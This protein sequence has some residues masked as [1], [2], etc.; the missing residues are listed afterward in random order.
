MNGS[1]R[2]LPTLEIP[3]SELRISFARSGGKG[4]QNVNKVE[5]KVELAFD[6]LNSPSLTP[7]QR[8]TILSKL[9]ARIDSRGVLSVTSQKYRSQIQNRN[10]AIEK[11]SALLAHALTPKKKR[12]KTTPTKSSKEKRLTAKK[13]QSE[14]KSARRTVPLS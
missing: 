3:Q 4:G 5:T 10:D 7:A 1:C 8:Q 6:V 9:A 14:K 2:I 11:F 13:R 12:M